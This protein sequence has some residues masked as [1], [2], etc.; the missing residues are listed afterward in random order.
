[1]MNTKKEFEAKQVEQARLMKNYQ[2]SMRAA[3]IEMAKPKTHEVEQARLMKNYQDSMRAA[4]IEMAKPK[5]HEVV[6]DM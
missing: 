2:D 1:M 3:R 5:T 6:V 4:R